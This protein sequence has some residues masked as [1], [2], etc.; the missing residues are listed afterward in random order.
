MSSSPTPEP[1]NSHLAS[2]REASQGFSGVVSVAAE[3]SA[4]KTP[5][6]RVDAAKEAIAGQVRR[7]VVPRRSL[8]LTGGVVAAAGVLAAMPQIAASGVLG[9]DVAVM[10]STE[11]LLARRERLIREN[12]DTRYLK[13]ESLGRIYVGQGRREQDLR[14]V[15]SFSLTDTAQADVAAAATALTNLSV[16]GSLHRLSVT[17]GGVDLANDPQN[18]ASTVTGEPVSPLR[19]NESATLK[20]EQWLNVLNANAMLG[21]TASY[22]QV[23]LLGDELRLNAVVVDENYDSLMKRF[24]ALAELDLKNERLQQIHLNIQLA[25]EKALS[26]PSGAQ[27]KISVSVAESSRVATVADVLSKAATKKELKTLVSFSLVWN[28][29]EKYPSASQWDGFKL[30][31]TA[32][33]SK[34]ESAKEAQRTAIREYLKEVSGPLQSLTKREATVLGEIIS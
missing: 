8:L 5:S 34:E 22:V 10:V 29:R 19:V 26:L 3:D 15:G 32:P 18:V 31:F 23:G 13:I 2:T 11:K 21:T 24:R 1:E 9:E 12:I 17:Y 16:Y 20:E 33:E 30:G 6:I 28:A 27:S 25:P 4:T 7:L 14:L